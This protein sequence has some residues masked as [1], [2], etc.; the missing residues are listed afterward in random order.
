MAYGQVLEAD[1]FT[2]RNSKFGKF[3]KSIDFH[4]NNVVKEGTLVAYRPG[5]GFQT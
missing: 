5:F 4:T 2:V 1:A 3:Q